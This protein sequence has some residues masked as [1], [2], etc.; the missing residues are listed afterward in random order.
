MFSNLYIPSDIDPGSP[1]LLD[2]S[3]EENVHSECGT[4]QENEKE[5]VEEDT[6]AIKSLTSASSK[7]DFKSINLNVSYKN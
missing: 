3:D 6:C 2:Q 1:E 4:N 7:F 5:D